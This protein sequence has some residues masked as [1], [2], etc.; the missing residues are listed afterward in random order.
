MKIE[1]KQ[2]KKRVHRHY[3]VSI[4][5]SLTMKL[6]KLKTHIYFNQKKK[7]KRKYLPSLFRNDQIFSHSKKENYSAFLWVAVLGDDDDI[8]WWWC[9]SFYSPNKTTENT[10]PFEKNMQILYGHAY[11]SKDK[12]VCFIWKKRRN[13]S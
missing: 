4:S 1:K 9:W 8:W 2:N 11:Y 5:L 13:M 7:R 3:L 12:T 6:N 10:H